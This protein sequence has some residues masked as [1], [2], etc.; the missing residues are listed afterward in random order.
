MPHDDTYRHECVDR[1][2]RIADK[3]AEH[4]HPEYQLA[5]AAFYVLRVLCPKYPDPAWIR[6]TSNLLK[7]DRDAYQW[8]NASTHHL[9]PRRRGQGKKEN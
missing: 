9:T 5:K 6:A 2:Q 7:V 1:L 8:A 4:K 3:V